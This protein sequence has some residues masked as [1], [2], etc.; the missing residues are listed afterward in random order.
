M[1]CHR[2]KGLM[3]ADPMRESS[4][5]TVVLGWR[6]L[7][8]GESID[9]VINANRASPAP[10]VRDRARVPGSPAARSQREKM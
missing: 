8:C 3:V 5:S 4:S 6:C 7:M 10:W 1:E 2:C 9:A